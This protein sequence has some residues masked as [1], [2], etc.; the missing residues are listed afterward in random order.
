MNIQQLFSLQDDVALVTGAGR[1]IGRAIAIAFAEAGASVICAA[2]TQED[3][4]ESTALCNAALRENHPNS[5]A[6]AIAISCDVNDESALESLVDTSLNTFSKLTILVNNAGGAYPNDPLNTTSKTLNR[7]FNFN[8]TSAFNLTRLCHPHLQQH[9]GRVINIISASS[10]YSQA[11]FSSYGTAKA[12]LEQLTKLLAA[13]FA[14]TIRVNGISPGTILT[15]ALKQYLNEEIQDK[16]SALTPMKSLGEPQD[17]A[18]AALYLASQAS[19]WVT[20]KIIEVDGGAESTTW[21]F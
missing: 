6:K 5:K 19:R 4:D 15:D 3:V 8:V 1:G 16:M 17:I 21:P 20:G 13:D 14:P 12:A 2:R 9:K 18:A 7:D 11:G 10:R